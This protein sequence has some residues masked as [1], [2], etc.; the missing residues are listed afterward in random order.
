MGRGGCAASGSVVSLHKID[1][2]HTNDW[3]CH[4]VWGRG[5]AR[6]GISG[7][8]TGGKVGNPPLGDRVLGRADRVIAISE[9]CRNSISRV[10]PDQ[11]VPGLQCGCAPADFQRSCPIFTGKKVDFCFLATSLLRSGLI[12]MFR[13]RRGLCDR[14]SE[15]Y[16]FHFAGQGCLGLA[17]ASLAEFPGKSGGSLSFT[18]KCLIPGHCLVKQIFS[19]LLQ[20][21]RLSGAPLVEAQLA[22]VARH[23]QSRWRPP[24]D[25]EAP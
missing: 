6:G 13:S 5:A 25:C 18:E 11:V 23:R 20:L 1:I 21:T 15:R 19:L 4:R 2:V 12:C 8:C 22:G 14:D 3:R 9:L 7:C 17:E 24:G 10:A 16:E